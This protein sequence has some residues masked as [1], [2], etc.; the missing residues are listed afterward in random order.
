MSL[1]HKPVVVVTGA[2]R[3]VGK[4]VA[5]ALAEMGATVYVTGRTTG[6][7]EPQAG[8]IEATA[9][10]VTRRGGT[11]IAIA[12][13]HRDDAQIK[14]LFEQVARDQGRLDVL[15]NNVFAV[16]DDLLH[17]APFWQKP[18]SYWDDMIDLGLRAHY[19]A[20][21]Y[22]AP[23]MVEQREGLIVN[24][25]SFGARCYI[26]TPIYGIGK[27]GADKMAHDMAKELKPHNVAALSLWLGVVKTE[28]TL[29]V[30]SVAP[31]A[32]A[33]LVDGME[34]P[35]YPGRLV[36]ALLERNEV[37]ARTAKTWVTAELGA[38]LG[39]RDIDGRIPSSYAAMLGEPAQPSE[40]MVG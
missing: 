1:H 23:L 11:G 8:S 34:S 19:L 39:V 10:E 28:R 29:E 32:Y 38:E 18:L 6:A 35:E 24:I 12:C 7:A 16:P 3:G 21:Y 13:D 5:L 14:A 17:P 22:A 25:S 4:G 27:A 33:D 40:A 20:S 37:M 36:R 31:E 30:M 26:H 9:A 15:V 2:S